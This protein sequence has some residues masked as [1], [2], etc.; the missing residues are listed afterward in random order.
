MGNL[1]LVSCGK[2][3]VAKEMAHSKE[4]NCLKITE[5]FKDKIIIITAGEDEYIRI[6][7]TKFLLVNQIYLR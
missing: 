3:I 5:L 6:W 2:H 4:I 7:D 1:I